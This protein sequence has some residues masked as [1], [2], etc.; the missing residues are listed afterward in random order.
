VLSNS[1]ADGPRLDNESAQYQPSRPLRR[2]LDGLAD[3]RRQ[4]NANAGMAAT[5][6][7]SV[8]RLWRVLLRSSVVTANAERIIAR[9]VASS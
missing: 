4:T 9:P 2:L 1:E 8:R 6:K 5:R 3:C 7:R